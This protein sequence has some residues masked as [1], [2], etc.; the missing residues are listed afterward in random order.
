MSGV[1]CVS[2][3]GLALEPSA[4]VLMN[5]PLRISQGPK[6]PKLNWLSLPG[7]GTRSLP[8]QWSGRCNTRV[9]SKKMAGGGGST[10]LEFFSKWESNWASTKPLLLIPD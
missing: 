2:H 5:S 9:D 7:R 10:I 3:L 4:L 1:E 8:V 6:V